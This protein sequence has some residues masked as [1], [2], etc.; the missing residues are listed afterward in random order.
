MKIC[1][2]CNATWDEGGP[3]QSRYGLCGACMAAVYAPAENI[4][5]NA[6]N[7]TWTAM[8]LLAMHSDAI[9]SW[10]P[11]Q[12]HEEYERRRKVVLSRFRAQA[13]RA[14]ARENGGMV[15][16]VFWHRGFVFHGTAQRAPDGT[17]NFYGAQDRTFAGRK[18]AALTVTGMANFNPRYR[19]KHTV[20][21]TGGVA[22][23][24]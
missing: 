13:E 17:W 14:K 4:E 7:S 20:E 19:G 24:E 8:K 23:V 22:V 2:R 11:E 9:N 6:A 3:V 1:M 16:A 10:T 5:E 21:K 18:V 12:L 15:D